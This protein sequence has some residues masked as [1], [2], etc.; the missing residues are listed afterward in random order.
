MVFG[1]INSKSENRIG[2]LAEIVGRR[3]EIEYLEYG[4]DEYPSDN[5]ISENILMLPVHERINKEDR[6]RSL[7]K[8]FGEPLKRSFED[9]ATKQ[10]GLYPYF[11]VY[12]R[13]T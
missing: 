13:S 6:P 2:K 3:D 5:R 9:N 10:S 12:L 11:S 4:L 8:V 7:S 1:K